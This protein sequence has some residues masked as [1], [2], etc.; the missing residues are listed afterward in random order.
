VRAVRSGFLFSLLICFLA[1]F[2]C[3]RKTQAYVDRAKGYYNQGKYEESTLNSRKAIQS[4]AHS[5]QAYYWLGLAEL[6]LGHARNAYDALARSVELLPEQEDPKIKLADLILS[7]YLFDPKR[8]A[9]L[10]EQASKLSSQLLA[11]DPNSYHALII[12][13]YLALTDR[14]PGLAAAFLRRAEAARP[15]Q[16]ET[17]LLLAQALMQDNQPQEG[18]R[19]AKQLI[20]RSKTY[21]PIYDVLY[22]FYRQTDRMAD[23][24]SVLRSKIANNPNQAEFMSQL[25][26]HFAQIGKWAEMKAALEPLLRDSKSFADGHLVAGD[27]YVRVRNFDG[28]IQQYE[29]GKAS[30]PSRKLVYE[31][32]L[33]LA[34]AAKRKPE[35]ALRMLD[36]ILKQEPN[37]AGSRM[38]RATLLVASGRPSAVDKGISEIKELLSRN[39]KDPSLYYRLGQAIERKGDIPG[40]QKEFLAAINLRPGYPEALLALLETGRLLHDY[41]GMIRYAD[42]LLALAPGN[43]AVRLNRTRGLIGMG[44]YDEAR[45]EL[46][47]LARESPQDRDVQ[48]ELAIIDARQG[49]VT[50]AEAVFRKYYKPGQADLRPLT[51]L[52]ELMNARHEYNRSLHLLNDDLAKSANPAA[53]RVLI[54]GA[55]VQA[56]QYPMAIA[57]YEQLLKDDPQSADLH[58][59][60]GST[61]RLKGELPK[62]IETLEKARKLEPDYDRPVEALGIALQ[63]AG[64]RK[65][66]TECYRKLAQLRPDDPI[67]LNNLAFLISE[68]GGNLDEALK[69]AGQ[70]QKIAPAD[71]AILDTLGSVY[72]RKKMAAA[73]IQVLGGL[74]SKYPQDPTYHYHYGLALLQGNDKFKARAELEMARQYN[75]PAD[76]SASITESLR[77]IP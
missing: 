73:A 6:K 18:E 53:V 56:H 71:P 24:E 23:A 26:M 34:L 76:I 22:S 28:A 66:A 59:A 70:A 2:S 25:A 36:E 7:D 57:Q 21:V 39:D 62:A 55:A 60:L 30:D 5:G 33:V 41:K 47:R 4:D 31:K 61:Y 75:P 27:F 14:H 64:R 51:G 8:P 63:I 29:T 40:A 20:E 52:M 50:A 37:D 3:G 58:V 19:V 44:A 48:L 54:A 43:R 46:R 72:L 68:T 67:V 69:L 42:R 12:K 9:Q 32:R 17:S 35:E 10:Y 16:P 1:S 13:T 49:N 45:S 65:E 77:K 11:K 38:N 74:V 15:N